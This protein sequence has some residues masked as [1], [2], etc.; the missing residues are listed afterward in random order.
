MSSANIKAKQ[1][2]IVVINLAGQIVFVDKKASTDGNYVI[3]MNNGVQELFIVTVK[4]I[5]LYE[6][7]K[8]VR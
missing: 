4:S 6:S 1:A 2:E 7:H 3:P 8:V 5:E